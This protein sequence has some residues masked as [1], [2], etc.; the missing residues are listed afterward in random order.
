MSYILFNKN[1]VI[2]I[3]KEY[4]D[5]DDV[6]LTT[7]KKNHYD[8]DGDYCGCTYD[9]YA[10]LLKKLNFKRI[11]VESEREEKLTRELLIEIFS[12]VL[13]ENYLIEYVQPTD[14]T[15]KIAFKELNSSLKLK[16]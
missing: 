10:T 9:V 13:G 6:K 8:N 11:K 14:K 7:Y 3:L 2:Q 12:N 1:Q 16:R 4:Y 15:Y 5:C